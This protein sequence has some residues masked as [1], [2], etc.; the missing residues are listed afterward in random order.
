MQRNGSKTYRLE[1]K[2]SVTKLELSSKSSFRFPN[3]HHA[4]VLLSLS[5]RDGIIMLMF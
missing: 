5:S 2:L 4:T 1:T 3:G